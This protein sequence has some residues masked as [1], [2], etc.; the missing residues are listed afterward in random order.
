MHIYMKT[1]AQRFNIK[2]S[3]PNP[4]LYCL[5]VCLLKGSSNDMCKLEQ[6]QK[7]F[8]PL[9]VLALMI[10]L[11]HPGVEQWDISHS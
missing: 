6:Q 5:Y 9:I 11:S 2:L 1:K 3:H 4:P 10:F 7:Q 8:L